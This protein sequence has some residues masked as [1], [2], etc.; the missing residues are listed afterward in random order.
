MNDYDVRVKNIETKNNKLNSD[1]ARSEERQRQL[2]ENLK[3]IKVEVKTLIGSASLDKL[4]GQIE[5][6]DAKINSEVTEA[7]NILNSYENSDMEEDDDE[8][9]FGV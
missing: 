6:L 5:A 9:D 8:D 7:E 2:M 4:N 3:E 1:K